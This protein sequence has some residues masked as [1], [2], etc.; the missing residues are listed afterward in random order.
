MNQTELNSHGTLHKMNWD[1]LSCVDIFSSVCS[2]QFMQ[3]SWT[4]ISL[5]LGSVTLTITLY[6][7]LNCTEISVQFSSVLSLC[8]F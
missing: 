5:Q 6:T 4:G 1:E 7:Q 2:V 3:R 8:M